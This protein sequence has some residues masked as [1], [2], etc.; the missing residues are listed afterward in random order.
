[1][2]RI[3]AVLAVLVVLVLVAAGCGSGSSGGHSGSSATT[4]GGGT[5][6][7]EVWPTSVKDAF[8]D[9]CAE[10][11]TV[12]RTQCRCVVNELEKAMSLDEMI[13]LSDSS[14]DISID[15]RIKRAVAACL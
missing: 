3:R 2:V 13:A 15:P 5:A 11:G 9:G 10:D 1:M 8:V 12:T 14:A 4:A 7:R 6:T